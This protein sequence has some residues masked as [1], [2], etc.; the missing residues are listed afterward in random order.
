[1]ERVE[2]VHGRRVLALEQADVQLAEEPGR[3]HPEIVAD[4]HDRLDALAV[5]VPQRG[6]QLGLL[7]APAGGEPLLELVED[8]QHLL[9]RAQRPAPPQRRHGIDEAAIGGQ[10]GAGLAQPAQQPGLGLLGRRLDVD[11]QHILAQPGSRPAL[12]I[13][14]LPQ[15]EGP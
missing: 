12:T 10:V 2:E 13:D 5:A 4:H 6:D 8:Q 1:M 3:G 9:P 15:P 14:D 11:R 7:L